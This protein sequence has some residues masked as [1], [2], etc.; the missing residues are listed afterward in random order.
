M[1][2]FIG[3]ATIEAERLILL[4]TGI[5][6]IGIARGIAVVVVVDGILGDGVEGDVNKGEVV[7][8]IPHYVS[9]LSLRKVH[10]VH[11]QLTGEDIT[12]LLS[13]LN[14][15]IGLKKIEIQEN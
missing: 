9:L 4:V 6:D 8:H 5:I 2:E 10:A 12:G 14:T 13:L 1:I 11:D 15:S 7:E 3:T